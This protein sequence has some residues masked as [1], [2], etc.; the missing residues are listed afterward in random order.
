MENSILKNKNCLIT[1][2]TGGLGRALSIQFAKNGCNLFLTS[3]N[4]SKLSS[5]EKDI[6]EKFSD[7]SIKTHAANLTNPNEI[8][9][10]IKNARNS[11]QKI[12]I[13]INC[14]GILPIK[15]LE[16]CSVTDFDNCFS[17]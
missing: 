17:L 4:M 11:F 13:L 14:A 15:F 10:I 7:I 2:A 3:Q 6:T 5:L 1:G 12:D 8:N 9:Q 16:D